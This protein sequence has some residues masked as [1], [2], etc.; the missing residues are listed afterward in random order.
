MK[1]RGEKGQAQAGAAR[2]GL[3]RWR[4]ASENCD[5]LQFSTRVLESWNDMLTKNMS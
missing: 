1:G 4:R 5:C 3:G 2:L